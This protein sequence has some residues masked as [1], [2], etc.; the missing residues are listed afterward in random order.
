MTKSDGDVRADVRRTKSHTTPYDGARDA[1]TTPW[2]SPGDA[3]A[4]AQT[5]ALRRRARRRT[6]SRATLADVARDAR[7]KARTNARGCRARRRRASRATSWRTPADSQQTSCRVEKNE[8]VCFLAAT[9]A[10]VLCAVEVVAIL[11]ICIYCRLFTHTRLA[12]HFV[13]QNSA[14][15]LLIVIIN[16]SLLII[17]LILTIVYTFEL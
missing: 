12:T 10:V 16:C 7:A 1:L 17:N 6:T 13:W 4:K 11:N 2:R 9:S 5:N 14:R 15:L 3:L 8:H